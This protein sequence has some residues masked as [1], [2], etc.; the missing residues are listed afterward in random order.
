MVSAFLNMERSW[1]R[2]TN[3]NGYR[4]FQRVGR[5]LTTHARRYL[6][7]S[8]T[9]AQHGVSRSRTIII[10]TGMELSPTILLTRSTS[11]V[12]DRCG[13]TAS[14]TGSLEGFRLPGRPEH[15]FR[16]QLHNSGS[17]QRASVGT[18]FSARHSCDDS[19]MVPVRPRSLITRLARQTDIFVGVRTALTSWNR[20]T[21]H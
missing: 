19:S 9:T 7:S 14:K 10:L 4:S 1:T 13:R 17:S 3:L 12:L 8:S 6:R 11:V 18:F 2:S 20:V 21:V 5:A 16:Q 15:V